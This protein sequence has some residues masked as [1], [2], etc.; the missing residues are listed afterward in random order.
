MPNADWASVTQGELTF[1]VSP[2]GSRAEWRGHR[3]GLRS[4]PG[5]DFWRLSA[6]TAEVRDDPV[7]SSVQHGSTN[8]GPEGLTIRYRGLRTASGHHVPVDLTVHVAQGVEG[9]EFSAD[10]VTEPGVQVNEVTLPLIDLDRACDDDRG[11]DVLY[12]ANGLG[13]RIV[14]PWSALQRAHSEYMSSDQREVW[15]DAVYPG[16][17]SMAWQALASSGWLV[18]LGRHDEQFRACVLSAGTGPRGGA[19]RLALSLTALPRLAAA[20]AIS[21]PAAVVA[22]VRGDWREGARIYGDWARST[23]YEPPVANPAAGMVGWQRIILKHQY[24]QVLF[25]YAD[26]VDV[27]ESGSRTGLLGL[28][29][30]GWWRRGFDR[31]YPEY[32]PDDAL[33]GVGELKAALA[34]IAARGGVVALYANGQLIDATSAYCAQFGREVARKGVNGEPYHEEYRFSDESK[35]MRLF[36]NETF[37]LGCHGAPR[38]RA[39]MVEV[40]R[41]SAE[42]GAGSVFLDQVGGHAMGWPCSD[43]SHDHGAR[44]DLEAAYRRQTLAAVRAAV[45]DALVGTEFVTDCLVG[46]VDY[47]HGVGFA[48]RDGPEA[49]PHLFRTVFPEPVVSNRLVHDQRDGW[50]H[51]L[52]YAFVFNLAFDVSVFRGRGGLESVPGYELAIARLAAL[53]RHHLRFFTSG[54][55]AAPDQDWDG[56]VVV[57]DYRLPDASLRVRWNRSTEPTRAPVPRGFLEPNEIHLTTAPEG[58]SRV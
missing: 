51:D 42:L 4:S 41:R 8:S 53:R 1:A 54:V 31:G 57:V 11:T 38:W 58:A 36:A 18:Y 37:V 50:L 9:L 22:L 7:H 17:L 10:V 26:L 44:P 56:P 20:Q 52:H 15:L 24:G 25:G 34:E 55:F 28:L 13:Q 19:P 23:W 33:G 21:T 45:G 47:H 48:F 6:Q 29:V 2:D 5:S 16:E 49:F 40:A 35:S 27:F 30:F 12:R 14:D 32:E 3:S 46:V 43:L 39:T